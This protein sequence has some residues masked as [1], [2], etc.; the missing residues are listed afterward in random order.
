MR[1]PQ[2]NCCSNHGRISKFVCHRSHEG[3]GSGMVLTMDTAES[4]LPSC[5]NPRAGRRYLDRCIHVGNRCWGL[6]PEGPRVAS[7]S[8][9]LY[10][11]FAAALDKFVTTVKDPKASIL[12]TCNYIWVDVSTV[13]LLP[14]PTRSRSNGADVDPWLY[15]GRIHPSSTCSSRIH[16]PCRQV[17]LVTSWLFVDV[18]MILGPMEWRPWPPQAATAG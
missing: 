8:M 2:L 9:A 15:S 17:S 13:S 3:R 10:P 16:Q 11:A 12:P 7:L 5:S 1:A 6:R 4:S 14:H 18:G